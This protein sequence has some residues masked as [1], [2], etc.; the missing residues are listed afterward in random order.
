MVL[1]VLYSLYEVWVFVLELERCASAA[2]YDVILYLHEVSWQLPNLTY[3]LRLLRSLSSGTVSHTR[4]RV[5]V[6]LT[7]NAVYLLE[8]SFTGIPYRKRRRLNCRLRVLLTVIAVYLLL[9][10]LDFRWLT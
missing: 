9:T 6:L 3:V 4:L 8:L 2:I 10:N 1:M 5:L 7:G